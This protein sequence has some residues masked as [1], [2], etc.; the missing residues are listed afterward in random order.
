MKIVIIASLA[1]S[2]MNFRGPLLTELKSKGHEVIA[3]APDGNLFLPEDR[4][5]TWL[6]DMGIIYHSIP[7]QRT[8][9]NPLRDVKSFLYLRDLFIKETPDIVCSYTIKPVIYGSLA[10][11]WAKVPRIYSIITGLGYTFMG[12]SLKRRAI[13]Y[14]TQHLYRR[15]LKNNNQ[16]FFQNPDDLNLFLELNLVSQRQVCQINGSGVDV[17]YFKDVDFLQGPP[18]FLLIARLIREKGILEYVEAARVIKKK[19]PQTVFQLL[20]AFDCGPSSILE[21]HVGQWQQ[22]GVLEYLGQTEDVRPFI[23]GTSV[24]VLPSYREGTPRSVLEAMSMGRPIITTDVPGCRETVIDGENGFLVPM[25]N[26]EA[27]VKVME[28]FIQSPY[29]IPK[30]GRRSREIAEE[31]FDVHKVNAVIMQTMGLS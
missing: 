22:E 19:Y 10:A 6:H 9:M 2:L 24:Y 23:A 27:L 29:L 31:K 7:L 20:G 30:M 11:Y 8:G 12:S 1:E 4:V 21:D 25:K 14:L 18:V 15:A 26:V 13:N 28:H 3:C 17:E 16:V 5:Q